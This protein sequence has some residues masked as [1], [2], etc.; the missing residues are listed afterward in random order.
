MF[1]I[2]V[3]VVSKNSILFIS[4]AEKAK[5]PIVFIFL[6]V[7]SVFEVDKLE[8]IPLPLLVVLGMIQ[9]ADV[10]CIVTFAAILP[11]TPLLTPKP[12]GVEVYPRFIVARAL[13]N[14]NEPMGEYV[15]P[16]L[17]PSTVFGIVTDVKVVEL[18]KQFL[19]S[20]VIVVPIN[21]LVTYGIGVIIVG[22]V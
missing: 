20:R 10:P 6:I 5:L 8:N 17:K 12:V 2:F 22:L 13:Q 3:R 4:L 11:K 14:A 21:K 19:E 1:P 18:V 7:T 9:F 15:V 16:P